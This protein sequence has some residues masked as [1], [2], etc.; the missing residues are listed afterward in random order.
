MT[1]IGKTISHC[2]ILDRLGVEGM[3]VVCK[4]HDA[5]LD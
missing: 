5:H 3:C 2:T 4:A 1:M